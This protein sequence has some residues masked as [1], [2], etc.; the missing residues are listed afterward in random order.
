MERAFRKAGS[1]GATKPG[2]DQNPERERRAAG[3]D[4]ATKPTKGKRQNIETP[5]E[6]HKAI[7]N[8]A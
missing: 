4:T 7:D 1:R 8:E 5:K 3:R 2:R 6:R